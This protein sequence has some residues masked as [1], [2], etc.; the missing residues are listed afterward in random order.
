M[1]LRFQV[2]EEDKGNKVIDFE[3]DNISEALDFLMKGR[4]LSDFK[5]DISQYLLYTRGSIDNLVYQVTL[6]DKETGKNIN[7]ENMSFN[8]ITRYIDMQEFIEKIC[9]E[10]ELEAYAEEVKGLYSTSATLLMPIHTY[11]GLP[12]ERVV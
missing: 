4:P 9:L 8:V 12:T 1:I 5:F 3:F 6:L 7:L 10:D 2:I 11:N